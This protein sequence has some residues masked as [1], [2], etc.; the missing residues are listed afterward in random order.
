MQEQVDVIR[1]LLYNKNYQELKKYLKDL[2]S[3]DIS[4][5]FDELSQEEIIKVYRLLAK[6]EAAEVFA[7][8]D[9][10]IQ[11]KL[12]NVFTDKEMKQVLD[13]LYMDDTVDL[14]EEMPSNIVKRILKH[15]DKED[16]KT[17]NKLLQY[18]DDSAGS[19]MTT[20]FID[21]KENMTVEEAL[22][23]VKKEA[24][25]TESIYTCYVLTLTR[26]IVGVVKL[27]DLLLAKL[28]EKISDLMDKNYISIQTLEDQE[29]VAKMFDKYDEYALPVVDNEERL[30]GII[31]IDDAMDIMREE[32]EEDFEKM[33][34]IIPSEEAYLKMPIYK[35]IL[36]RIGWLLILMF[37]AIL[38][39]S[40]LEHYESAFATM[41]ILV[42]FIPMI[43]GTGGNSGSQ[44]ST[45]MIRAMATEEVELKD[46]LKALWKEIRIGL[47]VGLGLFVVNSIRIMIQYQDLELCLVLGLTLIA[48]VLVSKSIGCLLPIFV[49]KIKL[50]PAVVAAPIITTLVDLC[51]IIIYF[52]IA[53]FFMAEKG[54]M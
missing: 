20:E 33:A 43:M 8:L 3:V 39:G 37:S 24:T 18:P 4:T 42:T 38:T 13:E 44:S 30:V 11:E 2:N 32:A 5:L 14:I 1:E 31:T 19:M 12:I 17:I 48:T 47:L 16:R 49:K 7:E 22:E 10:D 26:K 40:V 53:T 6:E 51:S 21:I 41:P 50:D 52:Q 15:I 29:N 45:I 25:K 28:D 27:K 34:A 36:H 46:W 23:E 9:S 35:H 54:V